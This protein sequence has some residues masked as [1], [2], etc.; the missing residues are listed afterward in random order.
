MHSFISGMNFNDSK[1][2]N[3]VKLFLYIFPVKEKISFFAIEQF[4][5]FWFIQVLL[6]IIQVLLVLF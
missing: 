4:S 3:N 5:L 1:P 6:F 2:E